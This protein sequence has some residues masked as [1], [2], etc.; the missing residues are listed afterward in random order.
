MY[1]IFYRVMADR[2]TH[3]WQQQLN[4]ALQQLAW[5]PIDTNEVA[6][7]E[8]FYHYQHV[9]MRRKW[10]LYVLHLTVD[11]YTSH[12]YCTYT[13]TTTIGSGCPEVIWRHT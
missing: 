9:S 1:S 2:Q 11:G 10:Q 3:I 6:M 8:L 12:V 13:A 5:T 4:T 7:I